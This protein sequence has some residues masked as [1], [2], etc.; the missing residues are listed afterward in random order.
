MGGNSV[1]I[2]WKL[3]GKCTEIHW[4]VWLLFCR[5]Q[6]LPLIEVQRAE[7]VSR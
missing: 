3:Y 1:E 4:K 7:N 2:V 6:G 5:V